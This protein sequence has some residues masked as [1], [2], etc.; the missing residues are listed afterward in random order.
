MKSGPMNRWAA[1]LA[2]AAIATGGAARP[3]PA[4]VES[5]ADTLAVARDSTRVDST[6]ADATTADATRAGS[7][8]ATTSAPWEPEQPI[9]DAEA[10]E[11]ALRMPGR[12]ATLPLSGLGYLAERTLIAVED[13][14]LIPRA[15]YLFAIAPQAGLTVG[16]ASLGDRTGFGVS[17]HLA[18]PWI[19]RYLT[20]NWDGST[21]EYNRT[22]VAARYGPARLDYAYEWRPRERFFGVGPGSSDALA[23]TYASQSQSVRLALAQRL[24]PS[25]GR[26]RLDL[27][28]WA[29]PRETI[30]RRGREP[31]TPSIEEGYTEYQS[32]L[33]HRIEHFAYGAR[34]ALD[35]RRGVPRWSRGARVAAE[36]ERFD[37]PVE[38]LALRTT[39]TAYR[40]TRVGLEFE[41]GLSF[42][43]DPRTFR[44]ALRVV[45]DVPDGSF[46]F[47][48]SD[49]ASLGGSRLAGFEPGRFHDVD[50]ALGRL[51]YLFPIATRLEIDLHVEAGNVYG[52]VWHDAGLDRLEHSYGIALRPRADNAVLGAL[53]VDWSREAVR[54]RFSVGGVE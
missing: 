53:G 50:S 44:L 10:W 11:T 49:L 40:F 43:R 4:D 42:R 36:V 12:I 2:A 24:A 54:I 39:H 15:V 47:L 26:W 16:P 46:T 13:A 45:D 8:A 25:D 34:V 31:G 14:N 3:V 1:V 32:V 30:A 41:G 7:L 5:A 18:L 28:G 21:L 27:A 22:R 33:N 17:A 23:T 48:P 37:R 51:S 38:A 6:M 35:G 52:D 19:R 9:A 20:A 29:G